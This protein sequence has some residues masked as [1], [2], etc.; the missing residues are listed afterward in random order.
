M[1]H[2]ADIAAEFHFDLDRAMGTQN[3]GLAHSNDQKLQHKFRRHIIDD[4]K[5]VDTVSGY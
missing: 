1:N 4:S 5:V 3:N 2:L